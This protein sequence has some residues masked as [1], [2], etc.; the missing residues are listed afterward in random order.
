MNIGLPESETLEYKETLAELETAGETICGFANTKGGV[1]Y[2][3]VKNSGDIVGKETIA[4]STIRRVSDTLFENFDPKIALNIVKEDY[5]VSSIIKISVDKSL[6]PYHTFKG[7]PFIRVGN[8]TRSMPITEHQKRLV[9][10]QISNKDFSATSIPDLSLDDL[11]PVAL[12]ELRKL[13]IGSGRYEIDIE[14]MSDKQLL[15]DLLL[16][17]NNK[18]TVAALL[19][20]G[21]EDAVTRYIPYAEIRYAYKI[22]EGE[23]NNQDTVI[24]RGG[25]LLHYN[26]IWEKIE[27]RNLVI[28]IPLEMKLATR[29]A[30]DEQT[31]REAVNNAIIHRDYQ[32]SESSFIFQYQSKLIVKSPGGLPDGISITNIIDES[33]PRNKLLAD[34]LFKCELVDQFGNGVNLM[35]K[36]Q[37]SNGKTPPDYKQTTESRVVLSLDGNIQDIEFA[38]YVM[39]VAE[40]KGKELNDAELIILNKIKSN[41]AIQ[42]S[43]ITHELLELGLIEKISFNRFMLSKQ[44][45]TDTNQR[46]KYT[47]KKGLSRPH[48]KELILEHL[49][50]FKG[51][52]KQ[53]I[54]G[55]FEFTLTNRQIADLIDD[56]KSE[57]KIY[58]DGIPRSSKGLW[59]L[60]KN[61][62]FKS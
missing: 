34:I 10:Y 22:T 16:I 4:E 42:F 53:E 3:G 59:R 33:S 29:K 1:V 27:S 51:A 24:Y 62:R 9:A 49:N 47:K 21:T 8:T 35:Y 61:R 20:L 28:N 2:I 60:T 15:K 40:K 44:Y 19:L 58:Y 26:K 43:S 46:A 38:K 13:L 48:N 25:Y 11:S 32:S 18:V 17:Q 36:N 52:N 30:F 5:G 7:K 50:N 37:L 54:A 41:E 12:K 55:M 14:H 56:L 31:I 6:T 45:Y 23:V 39:R 57:G